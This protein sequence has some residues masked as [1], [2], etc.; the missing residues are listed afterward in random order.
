[1]RGGREARGWARGRCGQRREERGEGEEGE[2]GGRS[3]K[4]KGK[5]EEEVP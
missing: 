1:M 4:G 2:E 3:G 5:E